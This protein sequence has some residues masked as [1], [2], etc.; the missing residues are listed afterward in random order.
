MKGIEKGKEDEAEK[1][2]E[3][4]KESKYKERYTI[5]LCGENPRRR[6]DQQN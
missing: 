6:D 2:S 3:N 4:A 5:D 1:K